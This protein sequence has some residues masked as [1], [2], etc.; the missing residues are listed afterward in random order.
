MFYSLLKWRDAYAYVHVIIMTVFA[1]I[2]YAY[3]LSLCMC[4]SRRESAFSW[5]NFNPS[6]FFSESAKIS[7]S[8][9]MCAFALALCMW[10]YWST[11]FTIDRSNSLWQF[12]A[13]AAAVQTNRIKYAKDDPKK[14]KNNNT[15]ES[16][17]EEKKDACK[18]L[19]N[20]YW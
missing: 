20:C 7:T 16:L 2:I 14:E 12:G 10:H 19:C 15:R 18:H 6:S 11:H 9:K 4:V 8:I 5:E 1:D 17:L 13:A 3:S